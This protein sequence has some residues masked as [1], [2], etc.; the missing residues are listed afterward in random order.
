V[1]RIL[2]NP[3][4]NAIVG[5]LA[6]LVLIVV[7]SCVLWGMVYMLGDLLLSSGPFPFFP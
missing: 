3:T 5:V 7:M 4:G 6:G 2:D 1:N